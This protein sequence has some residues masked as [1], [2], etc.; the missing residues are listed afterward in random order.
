MERIDVQPT[1]YIV[2]DMGLEKHETPVTDEI[3]A[4]VLEKN[5]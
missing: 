5:K 1:S 3:I 4:D 2:T